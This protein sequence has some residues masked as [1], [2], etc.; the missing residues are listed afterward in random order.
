MTFAERI[1]EVDKLFLDTA[2]VIYY[3][4]GNATYDGLVRRV[5][6]EVDGGRLTVVSSPVTLAE[7]LV[8]P[9]RLGMPEL[10]E[11]FLGT[12]LTGNNTVLQ[13]IDEEIAQTAAELRSRY[14]LTLT[15]AFQTATAMRAGC[16]AFLT[17]DLELKRVS[18][19][20]VL[21]LK[22]FV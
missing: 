1:Q 10:G 7:C 8:F 22:E 4:E 12:L 6:E 16:N 19:I 3:V 13:P 15:D 9:Y 17:N 14:N 20:E 21:V 2:P 5:F 11:R 18:E